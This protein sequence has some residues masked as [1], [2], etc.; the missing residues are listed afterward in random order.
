MLFSQIVIKFFK[1]FLYF[2]LINKIERIEKTASMNASPSVLYIIFFNFLHYVGESTMYCDA[3][4]LIDF[5]FAPNV[6]LKDKEIYTRIIRECDQ[7]DSR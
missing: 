2:K 7:R 4:T 1:I 3:Y 5:Q 6:T